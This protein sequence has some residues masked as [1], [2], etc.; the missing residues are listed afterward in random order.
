MPLFSSADLPIQKTFVG[1]VF[2]KEFCGK[3]HRTA[4]SKTYNKERTQKMMD[5][6]AIKK[7]NVGQIDFAKATIDVPPDFPEHVM[8]ERE[9]YWAD[10][11]GERWPDVVEIMEVFERRHGV[12][13]LD[14]KPAN[15]A[16]S[17]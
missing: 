8:E 4:Q 6:A 12:Y 9:A 5:V 14:P 3:T 16:F 10:L 2:S 1:I 11:F 7:R 13:L 17:N 15:I